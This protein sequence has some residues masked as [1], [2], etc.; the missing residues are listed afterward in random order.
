MTPDLLSIKIESSALEGSATY[1][2]GFDDFLEGALKEGC[3]FASAALKEDVFADIF[4][5]DCSTVLIVV[6]P[7]LNISRVGIQ[8][9]VEIIS[10]SSNLSSGI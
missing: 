6:A 1:K 8:V 7:Q 9:V 2:P 10:T 5:E 3:L 4:F